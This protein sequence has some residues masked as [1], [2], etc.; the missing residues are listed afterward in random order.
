MWPAAP[1]T[2]ST[3]GQC[4]E[5]ERDGACLARQQTSRARRHEYCAD[6][7][8]APPWI[9]PSVTLRMAIAGPEFNQRQG[10]KGAGVLGALAPRDRQKEWS[11]FRSDCSPQASLL[12]RQRSCRFH[13]ASWLAASLPKISCMA[14]R[15]AGSPEP[16]RSQTTALQGASRNSALSGC[17][18]T[19][20]GC[21]G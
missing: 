4:G 9:C 2:S 21:A 20:S 10:F 6:W 3:H 5:A 16:R 14:Q 7:R 19:S 1:P 15:R 18:G 11:M 13:S 12:V 17:R 8:K